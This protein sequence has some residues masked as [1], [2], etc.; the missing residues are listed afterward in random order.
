MS[1]EAFEW[2]DEVEFKSG[3]LR[4]SGIRCNIIESGELCDIRDRMRKIVGKAADRILYL[5][6]KDHTESF[7][8][9]VV[10]E[11]KLA[12]VASKMNWGKK[13][14]MEKSLEI[15]ERDGYGIVRIEKMDLEELEGVIILENSSIGAFYD[16]ESDRNTCSYIAGL[17]AGGAKA[18][19]GVDVT[20]E[21]VECIG[22]GDEV[23]KFVVKPSKD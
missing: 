13:K 12:R 15:L 3:E 7:V 19:M 22:K 1:D 17:I 6:A 2:T 20:C 8:E 16:G 11:S 10:E 14:I 21:E 18:V 4:V 9:E 5:S 23:C